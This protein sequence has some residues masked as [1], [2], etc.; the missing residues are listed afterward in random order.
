LAVNAL[1]ANSNFSQTTIDSYRSDIATARSNV[2]TA[3]SNLS[4]AEESLRDAES[5]L[6]LAKE[7]L[8]L[9]QAG[10]REEQITAQQARVEEARAS[11]NNYKVEIEKTILFSPFSGAITK[12]EAEVGE[13]VAA[14]SAIISLISADRLLIETNIPE[15]D[16]AKLSV[17]DIARVTLDAYGD[18][19]LFQA[20]VVSIE[21]AETIIEGIS[22]YKT[23]LQ[24]IERDERIRSGMTANIDISTDK[25]VDVI[26]VPQ[27]A[28]ITKNGDKIVRI[29]TGGS[30]E[31]VVVVTGLRGSDGRVEIIN[32]VKGGDKVII[33]LDES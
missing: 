7:E 28:V 18:D 11:V 21:P 25:K 3:I 24:F 22:T 15:A 27:R 17:D 23:K 31:E 5:A 29:L 30:V 14:N 13:I 32:G 12:R 6:L 26:A 8:V 19:V 16:I 9:K 33:F 1:K 4:A 10:A 20:R 2:N